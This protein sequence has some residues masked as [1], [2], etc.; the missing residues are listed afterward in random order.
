VLVNAN[1]TR[2]ILRM[3]WSRKHKWLGHI[4]RLE[5]LLHDIIEWKTMG[6][7]T[8]WRKRKELLH[9]IMEG[10]DY[11]QLKVLSSDRWIQDDM[12]EKACQKPAGDSR[13]L[14]EKFGFVEFYN[15][16]RVLCTLLYS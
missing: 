8:R 5:G 12:I 1:E 16:Y 7:P 14:K 11:G 4:V 13:R 2:Y 10:R 15:H 3:I 9:N 6:R